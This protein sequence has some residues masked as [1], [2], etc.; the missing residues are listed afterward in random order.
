[1]DASGIAG[2]VLSGEAFNAFPPAFA[3]SVKTL[4][5]DIFSKR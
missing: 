2:S 4:I 1:M 3:S 5:D